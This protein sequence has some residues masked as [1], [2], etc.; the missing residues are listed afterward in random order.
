M[1]ITIA[2]SLLAADFSDLRGQIALAEQGGADWIHLDIMD[3]HFV[4]NLTIG[5]L[6]IR[7]IRHVTT[8]P[9][10]THLMITNPDDYLEMFRS[11]GADHLTVHFEACR[12]LNRTVRRIKE[13]G[14]KAGV[15]VN[16]ATP[17]S[18]LKD[19][20]PDVDLVLLM[21]VNPGFGGQTFLPQSLERLRELTD[22]IRQINPDVYLEVD[23]GIDADTAGPVVEAGANVLVAGSFIY[24]TGDVQGAIRRLR[25]AARGAL[26]PPRT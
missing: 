23:G 5:P 2:P 9:F 4:P 21:S 1:P 22:M 24:R 12:S 10:D 11:A 17:V 15:S 3:G 16:P 18:V 19:T 25:E 7:S 20:I 6:V 14:A 26:H 13:L 8:L